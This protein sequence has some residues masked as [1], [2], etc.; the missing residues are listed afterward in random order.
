MAHLLQPIILGDCI[1]LRNRICMGSM[2]RN[3]CVDDAKPT[4]ATARHYADRARDGTGLII[5][6]GAFVSLHGAEWPHAP[7]MFDDSH[8]GAWKKVTAAV[9]EQGGRIFFQPWHPG[10][11]QHEDMPML[12]ES[13]Y[14][15]LAPSTV[16]AAGGKFRLLEGKPGHT[17]NITE[18]GDPSVIVEQFK[19]SVLLAQESGF[20]GIEL[21]CQGGYL[22]HNFLCSHANK[23]IDEY[24]GTI[25]NRCR[26][27]LQVLDAII[28]VWGPRRVGIKICPSDDY[29][30]SA[31]SYD[32]LSEVYEY[33]IRQLV[34]RELGY[35]ELSRRGSIDRAQ[36]DYFKTPP[37]L[38]GK[39]LPDNYDTIAQFGP[40]V[41]YPGSKSLLM[42]NHEYTVDE[43][44]E[45]LREN[46]ADMVCLGRPFI[47]NPDLI[48]RIKNGLPFAVNDRGGMVNYGPYTTPDENY[49]DWPAASA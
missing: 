36:D 25:E 4:P 19:Q 34:I 35:I 24:G 12:K 9:H 20:D 27:P 6:E 5:A 30:D 49:N 10:R 39:E 41:K 17:E 46:K 45:L 29:N 18:I 21:L 11:I 37:R 48:T 22:L 15:V 2:T 38:Q 33:L 7:V 8:A 13:G 16:P 1:P 44:E 3:R 43:A 26:F 31:V 47:Y 40:L 32:E 23:R 14:P 42:V 28:S